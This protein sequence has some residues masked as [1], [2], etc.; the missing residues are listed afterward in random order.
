[1]VYL[2]HTAFGALSQSKPLPRTQSAEQLYAECYMLFPS[3]RINI[4]KLIGTVLNTPPPL[5]NEEP[6][7]QLVIKSGKTSI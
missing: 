7:M 5:K 6:F 2:T 4:R 1:M 3:Q